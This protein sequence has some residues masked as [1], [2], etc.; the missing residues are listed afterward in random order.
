M[1]Q[2]GDDEWFKNEYEVRINTNITSGSNLTITITDVEGWHET[3][4]YSVV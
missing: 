1:I 3:H 4:R 2:E